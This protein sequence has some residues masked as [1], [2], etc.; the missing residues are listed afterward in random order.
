MKKPEL[1]RQSCFCTSSPPIM[2]V[3]SRS[4]GISRGVTAASPIRH[5]DTRRPKRLPRRLSLEALAR[6]D[7][8]GSA[9]T[10]RG[11]Q[12]GRPSLYA[13]EEHIR[14]LTLPVLIVV[15]DED[16]AC[17]EPS[18]F[19][20]QNV[21]ASGLAMFPKTGHVLNLEEPALFN[22]T[23]A[24]FLALAEADRWPPRDPASRRA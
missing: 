20:K 13:F 16:D 7:A 1:I 5:G 2:Q 9:H 23:L 10:Q 18:L 24:R 8:Q 19:L 15:G 22:E 21:P 14:H 6:H 17:I 3:G 12:G 11:F 4:C